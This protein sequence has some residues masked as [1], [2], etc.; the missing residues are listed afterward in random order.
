MALKILTPCSSALTCLNVPSPALIASH[1]WLETMLLL[2]VNKFSNKLGLKVPNNIPRN[3]PVY[4]F[5]SFL[6]VSLTPFI[7]KQDLSSDLTTFIISF[8]SPLE[9]INVVAPDPNILLW[10]A[11]FV[12]GADAVNPKV[13]KRF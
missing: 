5:V 6:I 13:L 7:N 4:S 2:P 1:P 8:I 3:P 11:A 9:I 12:G 10:I